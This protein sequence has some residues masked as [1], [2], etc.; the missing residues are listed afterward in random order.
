MNER[1][2]SNRSAFGSERLEQIR[3][4]ST[5]DGNDTPATTRRLLIVQKVFMI[6]HERVLYVLIHFRSGRL[7]SFTLPSSPPDATALAV[8]SPLSEGGT[9]GDEIAVPSRTVDAPDGSLVRLRH[10]HDLG[11]LSQIPDLHLSVVESAHDAVP[12]RSETKAAHCPGPRQRRRLFEETHAFG[13]RH[14]PQAKLPVRRGRAEVTAA[15]MPTDDVHALSMIC[16]QPRSHRDAPIGMR[17]ACLR[18][19]GWVPCSP[20]TRAARSDPWRRSG[21]SSRRGRPPHPALDTGGPWVRGRKRSTN[22]DGGLYLKTQ[23]LALRFSL[24]RRIVPSTDPLRKI[25]S[26]S[27]HDMD[28]TLFV[29]P[30]K[31]TVGKGPALDAV[32]SSPSN[33]PLLRTS[34]SDF[35]PECAPQASDSSNLRLLC[36]TASE[37]LGGVVMSKT[38]I[39]AS[40]NPTG[41][42]EADAQRE[43]DRTSGDAPAIFSP[44][45]TIDTHV[46][47]DSPLSKVYM[48][49]EGSFC[50]ET[51]TRCRIF[52][53][54]SSCRSL[55]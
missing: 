44:S 43:R 3:F 27:N 6:L 34:R 14:V 33:A 49:E 42:G 30:R 48:T 39:S 19:C 37:R 26:S 40:E 25:P 29:W 2:S 21:S 12:V 54:I 46:A 4:H 7:H 13:C 17:M 18:R 1:I 52:S 31:R 23:M 47:L 51:G 5:L 15:G 36:R 50:A 32:S 35:L 8:G 28:V 38:W 53:R 45:C 22:E 9:C 16:E 20:C 10:R 11:A 24:Q 55:L 41:T